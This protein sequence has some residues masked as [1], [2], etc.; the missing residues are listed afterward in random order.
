MDGGFLKMTSCRIL[1]E[2][3][4][5]RMYRIIDVMWYADGIDNEIRFGTI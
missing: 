5:R 4:V 3:S 2:A 1:P